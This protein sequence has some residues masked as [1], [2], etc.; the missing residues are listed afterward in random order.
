[1]L[2]NLESCLSAEGVT[3]PTQAKVGEEMTKRGIPDQLA[4]SSVKRRSSSQRTR[5]GGE[6]P[7][8]GT[9]VPGG[10]LPSLPKT[11]LWTK[12]ELVKE[13]AQSADYFSFGTREKEWRAGWGDLGAFSSLGGAG[14]D[15]GPPDEA[16]PLPL[17]FP[18]PAPFHVSSHPLL[19]C[20]SHLFC[21]RLIGCMQKL[22]FPFKIKDVRPDDIAQ[23]PVCLKSY[24]P[25]EVVHLVSYT[26]T[27]RSR[28]F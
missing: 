12:L 14:G 1:M 15:G 18:S 4:G 11:W 27:L 26:L 7:V 8:P 22:Y 17:C 13:E 5:H 23:T 6:P 21:I 19:V 9:Q 24:Q 10:L 3:N 25:R 16:P 2:V 20:P 28:H